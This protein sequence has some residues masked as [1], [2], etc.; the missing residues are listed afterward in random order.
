MHL[1]SMNLI[2]KRH[3]ET[4][5]CYCVIRIRLCIVIILVYIWSQVY[6]WIMFSKKNKMFIPDSGWSLLFLS[7]TSITFIEL[8]LRLRK[9]FTCTTTP[10]PRLACASTCR[11]FALQSL[12]LS[13][14]ILWCISCWPYTGSVETLPPPSLLSFIASSPPC[15]NEE[16]EE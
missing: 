3:Y 4:S 9:R 11:I 10:D 13:C 2:N 15:T 12:K 5:A 1:I 6:D 14:I 8:C 16:F 7:H